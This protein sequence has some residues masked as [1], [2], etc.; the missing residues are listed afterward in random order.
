MNIVVVGLGYVGC[1]LAFEL[2]KHF[3]V[4][5][6]D[7]NASRVSELLSGHDRTGEIN[8]AVVST[9]NWT[10]T[11]DPSC[12]QQANVVIVTVP[13][14]IAE[15]NV[16]DLMPVVKATE[17]IEKYLSVG[18]IV[19]YESTV[20]PGVTEELCVPILS[21]NGQVWKRDFFVAYSPERINPG[22]KV[23]TLTT[24]TK[25]VSGDTPETLRIVNE[26]YSKI[27]NTYIASS[28]K[29]A[30]AAKVIE[31][32]QRDVNI[33]LMNE[34]S[35]IFKRLQIDTND[36]IDAAAS[37]WNFLTFRPGLVG[38]HC[39][40]VD[41]YYLS[42][43]A[44]VTGFIADVILSAREIND[45]MAQFIASETLKIMAVN[46]MLDGNARVAVLGC[47]FKENVPDIR[48]SKVFDIIQKLKNWGQTALIFDPEADPVEVQ[49]EYGVDVLSEHECLNSN[50]IILA[51][52]HR[53]LS[54]WD[55]VMKF[56][57]P[58]PV[59]VVD[60]KGALDRSQRPE[61]VELWRP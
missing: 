27:T 18:S 9:A 25:I 47:T 31:N 42:H 1:P 61:N 35:Q 21:R 15:A 14:P 16:P 56:A 51:V 2:S 55:A 43:K 33:A 13:T 23:N 11:T 40:S 7:I 46:K 6:F 52:P 10:L 8:D 38:G 22:D 48:N 4:T 19:V 17:M 3:A 45:S 50:V 60:V 28:I 49:H 54:T 36:V 30:E 44:E 29:V 20:Y 12:I 57:A 59:I 24:V 32:T 41:P 53:S 5:G 39:I 58:G 26:V 37:K 34:L